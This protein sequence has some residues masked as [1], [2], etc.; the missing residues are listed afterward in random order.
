MTQRRPIEEFGRLLDQLNH[1]F[2]ETMRALE[3]GDAVEALEAPFAGLREGS[4]MSVDVLDDDD[5]FVVTADLPGFETDEVSVRVD[6]GRLLIEAER[7]DAEEASETEA[8]GTYLRR[9][10]S[11]RE[12]SRSIPLS[13]PVDTDGITASMKHGVLTVHLPKQDRA[14]E[15]PVTIDI[16]EY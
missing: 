5:E 6:G 16:N 13:V 11:R 2:E 7:E 12:L 3:R 1:S 10:R 9:E 8:G 4:W 15:G 14:D